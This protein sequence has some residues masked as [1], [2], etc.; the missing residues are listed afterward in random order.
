MNANIIS[1]LPLA[2]LL[3]VAPG[4]QDG[5]SAASVIGPD[6]S[7][8]CDDKFSKT[9]MPASVDFAT[10]SIFDLIDL[11]SDG[12]NVPEVP[13]ELRANCDSDNK[14]KSE[15]ANVYEKTPDDDKALNAVVTSAV[16]EQR[17]NVPENKIEGN[18]KQNDDYS[19]A[20]VLNGKNCDPEFENLRSRLAK[21]YPFELDP[22]QK[23]AILCMERGDSVFVAA[24]TSAGK[25]VV[26]E[27]AIALCNIHKTRAIYTSPIK[28]L[29]NEKFRDFKLQFGDV[30]LITGD[31]Q[32]HVDA[33]ALVMTTEVL[34]SM[35]YNG[36]EAIRELEWVIF[37]EVH[38]INDIER[39]HVWEEVLIMLPSHVKIVMLSATVPNCVEFADWVGRI[40]KRQIYVTTT[41]KRPVPLEHFLYTGQ[42]AKTKK[43]LFKIVD[44]GGNFLSN[45]E[46]FDD[47]NIYTNLIKYLSEKNLLPVVV[48]VFSRRRCDENALLL[49]SMDLTT[50]KEKSYI[51]RFFAKCV[52]RLKGSD[53]QLP[54]VLQVADLC[55]RGFAIHHSG[56]LPILKEIVEILFQKGFVKVLFATETFAM[57]VNMPARTV[58]FDSMMK[59][60][61]KEMRNLTPSE[62][63][64]MAG[65]AGRRGLDSTGTVIVLCKGS[66]MPE[67]TGLNIMM[68]GKPLKLES[69]FRITYSMLLNLLRVEHLRIEDMLQH[70]YLESASL[71]QVLTRQQEMK[72]LAEKIAA[73]PALKCSTC[74]VTCEE[75]YSINEYH[76]RL[77]EFVRFRSELWQ[78]LFQFASFE[79]MFAPGR[80]VI[81]ALPQINR[82]SSLAMVLKV[83]C[84]G[85]RRSLQLLISVEDDQNT[86]KED[87]T[88]MEAFHKLPEREQEW[89][90]E[91]ALVE[92]VAFTGFERLALPRKSTKKSTYRIL[93]NI[94]VSSL[95][96][97]CQKILRVDAAT[98]YNDV[99]IRSMPRFRQ[100]SPDPSITKVVIAMDTLAS[101][102]AYSV[103]GADV[104]LPGRDIQISSAVVFAKIMQLNEL[105]NF[106]IVEG[107]FPCRHCLSFR[108]HFKQVRELVQ[109]QEKYENLSY[110]L[111]MNSLMLS[112]EYNEHLQVLHRLGYID[113]NNLIT[114]KGKVACEIHNQELL[115]TELLLDNKLQSRS[116]AEIA[117]MLSST[118]AQSRMSDIG[119]KNSVQNPVLEAVGFFL[120]I[121]WCFTR[122][123]RHNSLQVYTCMQNF[124]L[125]L[126]VLE[127]SNK[128]ATAQRGCGVKIA[129]PCESLNFDLIEVVYE[130][131]SGTPFAEIMKLTD[132]QEGFIVRCIQRLDEICRDVR[133]AA[134]LIGDPD[135]YEKM[136]ETSA[137]IRRDIV[138]AASLYT[139]IE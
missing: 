66:Q 40:K 19:C 47:K 59:H 74:C 14:I 124:Q 45:G 30:G 111:S 128:I 78:D 1:D 70:S 39:G 90:I 56:I 34:R 69:R 49:Q 106:L 114:L 100:Q 15:A 73:Y 102:W 67:P 123:L 138:F 126:D 6:V 65:R 27:Y 77:R 50:A 122:F 18:I 11:V 125:K 2:E 16:V 54:Q 17:V 10:A 58:V 101:K 130:W 62:Y 94:P 25:T 12:M 68:L 91:S 23:Q 95:I 92:T 28:A 5:I 103:E 108:Q 139:V 96:A 44:S 7:K 20:H 116:A 32:L 71:R 86:E 57:G 55:K 29:S 81:V 117:A 133:C 24:H 61:G 21:K 72:Q 119:R 118:T 4:L 42:D 9:T 134:R 63:I 129:D 60:D 137:A 35:L 110:I 136:D 109:M 132:A 46:V 127:V 105:R 84:D 38:Y 93:D 26:A 89:K 104:A 3:C 99:R 135:L 107:A 36:S 64:Q 113:A 121:F 98:V 87:A 48:F 13:E 131:A 43:D 53:K 52:A 82:P 41:N 33:F 97:V 80:L 75:Y 79:K 31:I 88:L 22:F 115:I 83:R 51:H 112:S 8:I 37:D 120:Q 85:S 76:A